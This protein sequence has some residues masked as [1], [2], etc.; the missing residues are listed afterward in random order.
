[1]TKVM[2]SV[3]FIS[4]RKKNDKIFRWRMTADGK[5]ENLKRSDCTE[6]CAWWLNS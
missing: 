6:N 4:F 5:D 3:D 1:M 2:I